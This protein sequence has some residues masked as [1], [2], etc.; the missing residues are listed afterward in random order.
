MKL[1]LQSVPPKG[2]R[3]H[4]AATRGWRLS[5]QIAIGFLLV[6][7]VGLVVAHLKHKASDPWRSPVLLDLKA[8]LV[9]EPR[10]EALKEQIRDLDLGLRKRYFHFLSFKATG[11]YLL[12][13]GVLV[14]LYAGHRL[15]EL[16]RGLPQPQPDAE[17]AARWHARAHRSRQ[18]VAALGVVVIGGLAVL[19]LTGARSPLDDPD[20]LAQLLKPDAST[21]VPPDFAGREERRANWPRFRGAE[22]SGVG[23]ADLALDRVPET[24]WK[25][26]SPI[27]GFGSPVIWHQRL[28]FSGGDAETREVLCLSVSSGD[29]LWRQTVNVAAPATAEAP[30]EIPEMTGYAAPTVA[31]DGKRLYAVFASGELAAF[32]LDGQLLWSKH[33]GTLDNPYG[34]ASSLATWQDQLIIQLDQGDEDSRL[35]K[36]I[37]LDGPTGEMTW[38]RARPVGASWATPIVIEEVPAPQVITLGLP[39]VIAYGAADGTELWRA[40]L[41]EG[42][43]TPSPVFAGGRLFIVDPGMYQLVAMRVDGQGDVTETHVLW[44]VDG[45]MPDIT[46]PVSDGDRVYTLAT[47]GTL[48]CFRASDGEALWKQSLDAGGEIQ[49]SPVL[50]GEVLL[51]VSTA[52]DLFGVRDGDAFRELWRDQLDDEFYASPACA[53]GRI[54]LRGIHNVWCLGEAGREV[55][56]P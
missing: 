19:V 47:D 9:S 22:G 36:I 10:N 51:I 56:Q 52:G 12:F 8:Q 54:Y 1:P 17:A 55:V 28:M 33:L 15:R 34:H 46:S 53:D 25:V 29:L 5:V 7:G 30:P 41:L 14:L 2:T 13:G 48:S 4:A 39:W 32:T 27:P 44:R 3:E 43:I 20:T 18:A 24:L 26:P 38:Q 45:D 40:R 16:N 21:V 31:T 37:V 49:A 42:E 6:V 35:S 11:V 23:S 50:I